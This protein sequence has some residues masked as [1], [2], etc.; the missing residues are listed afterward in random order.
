MHID[1][2]RD[3]ARTMRKNMTGAERKLWSALKGRALSGYRFNRQV[4]LGP[5][6]VD[7][8]CREKKLIVEVDGVT[9]GDG[10]EVIADKRRAEFLE[11]GGYL[12]FRAWNIDI[13]NNLDGVLDGLLQVLESRAR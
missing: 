5:Y 1:I 12:V 11:T 8:L 10:H 9:H 4:E 7:F 3:H 6:I 2:Q 13:Y